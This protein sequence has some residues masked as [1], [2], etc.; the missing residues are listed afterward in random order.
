MVLYLDL[1][2]YELHNQVSPSIVLFMCPCCTHP[3]ADTT[4]RRFDLDLPFPAL[5]FGDLFKAQV[6]LAVETHG[7]HEF[8]GRHGVLQVSAVDSRVLV[9]D[10]LAVLIRHIH[11][12]KYKRPQN[13]VLDLQVCNQQGQQRATTPHAVLPL[14]A[15]TR[16]RTTNAMLS[17]EQP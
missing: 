8:S 6:F 7:V 13:D 1:A 5:R 12:E 3:S 16:I 2:S 10:S 9:A 11:V 4:P 14:P 17:T 15:L